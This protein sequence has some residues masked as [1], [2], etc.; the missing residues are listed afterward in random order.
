MSSTSDD[1]MSREGAR[2]FGKLSAEIRQSAEALAAPARRGSPL[3]ERR[4]FRLKRLLLSALPVEEAFD[5]YCH[6][7][8]LGDDLRLEPRAI[9][10]LLD[11]ARE[12]A[13]AFEVLH[14]GGDTA[15]CEPPAVRGP[16]R[17]SQV[18]GQTRQVFAAMFENVQVQSRSGAIQLGSRLLF[19]FQD[20]EL[21]G[22]SVAHAFDPIIFDDRDSILAVIDDRSENTIRIDR[23][24]TLVGLFSGNF[25]HWMIEGILKFLGAKHLE[26]LRGIPLLIDE[27]MP[28]QHR[29]ALEMLA[30]GRFPIV[31]IPRG[32]C[33][34]AEQLWVTSNWANV[35]PPLEDNKTK[36]IVLPLRQVAD[37]YAEA[38]K[39]I[40][41]HLGDYETSGRT[42]IARDSKRRDLVNSKEIEDLLQERGFERF[43]PEQHSFHTQVRKIRQSGSIVLQNGA[44]GFGLLLAR[45]GTKVICLS[46]P[47]I[48]A[49]PL[50]NEIFKNLGLEFKVVTGETVRTDEFHLDYSDYEIPRE[51][52]R[53]E[54]DAIDCQSS[55]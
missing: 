41:R 25:G 21:D 39:K 7:L 14:P 27:S 45:S 6:L 44:A 33:V 29:Q 53:L 47:H 30:D 18:V 8:N 5:V 35:P 54:L 4:A 46:H 48:E 32:K 49:L 28:H 42:F 38:A 50:F 17:A 2:S 52:L 51:T 3:G 40:D 13:V 55:S 9:E 26:A 20:G 37:I 34:R 19:D 31:T 11:A 12:D 10:S 24:W 23:A 16:A 43:L 22:L 1:V 15:I 36:S